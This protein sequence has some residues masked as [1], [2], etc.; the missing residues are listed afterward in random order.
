MRKKYLFGFYFCFTIGVCS[1]QEKIIDLWEKKIPNH[2][3]TN[4][5]EI[6]ETKNVKQIKN[7]QK[8]SI[9]VF[10]PSKNYAS[11]KAILIC[12]GGG[13]GSISYDWEGTEVAKWLNS[14]GIAAFVLKYRLPQS[15][16]IIIPYKAPL[17]DAKR[18]IRI[19]RHNAEIW[20]IETDQIGVIGFSAGGHL[21]ATLGTQ[22]ASANSIS[23]EISSISAKPNFM[24]LLYPVITMKLPYTHQGSRNNLLGTSPKQELVDFYSNEL[25]INQ[26]TPPTFIVHSTDDRV[27]PV[28]NSLLFYQGLKNANIPS[29]LHIYSKGGHGFGLAI[30]QSHIKTWT[31]RFT[32]WI[33]SLE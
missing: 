21:A 15:K 6:W 28:E 14:K 11:G 23:D 24:A 12:P 30:Q 19:I 16:S 29:E 25:Q 33:Q 26:N 22:Y 32:D 2:Q 8:P 17:Q 20:N 5:T 1:G 13:Y 10:L 31:D 7:V 9:E 18:A 27:V 4:E 3:N